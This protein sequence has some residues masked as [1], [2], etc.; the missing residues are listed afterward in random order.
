SG[1]TL[2]EYSASVVRAIRKQMLVAEN[3]EKINSYKFPH[4]SFQSNK[5]YFV[6]FLNNKK[7]IVFLYTTIKDKKGYLFLAV[8]DEKNLKENEKLFDK[9]FASMSIK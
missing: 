8:T 4:P 5:S 1:M 2:K 9:T 6:T 7:L 3:Q